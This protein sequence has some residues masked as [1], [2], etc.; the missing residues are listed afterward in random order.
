M[1]YCTVGGVALVTGARRGIG[2]AICAELARRGFDIAFT[3]IV[4]DEGV[5][6]T[7]ALVKD[8]GRRSMFVQHDISRTD[9]HA[10]LVGQITEELGNIS[11]LVN[12][13]GVQVSFRGDLLDVDPTEF[14]HIIGVNL[15]GTFF[16]TQAVAKSMLACADTTV[17]PSIVTITSSNAYLVS[18]EKS[19][20]C[21][22]KAGL[23]MA[24]QTFALR[25]AEA[26]IRVF[27]VRPG[28]IETDMTA[29]VREHYSAAISNGSICAMRRWG[30]PDDIARVI[31]TLASGDM[32]YSTGDIYNVGGGMHIPRL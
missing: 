15:R 14:D 26:G 22:S 3:D 24:M 23:S 5:A 18:P 8:A 10:A 16:L 4:E 27:E 1:N 20:Y 11:C 12:N 31:G 6:K 21:A 17:S 29:D 32:P 28:L 7:N 30:Q 2:R 19:V 25:L 13:A 9:Q